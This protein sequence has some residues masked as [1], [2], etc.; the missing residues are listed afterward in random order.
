M[1]ISIKKSNQPILKEEIRK[2]ESVIGN[3]LPLDFRGFLLKYNGGIPETN[4][5]DIP[6]GK[7]SSGVNKFLSIKEILR[8]KKNL[9]SRL[10]E[11][12]LPIASAEGGNYVCLVLGDNSGIYYWDHELEGEE[13]NLPSWKNMFFLSQS[14]VKFEESLKKFDPSRVKLKPGQVKSAWIDP[15][16]LD[17]LKLD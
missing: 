7:N 5:F 2:L 16:F 14:F 12:A 6:E 8:E 11:Q 13:P 9:G 3:K 17:S 15:D 4:E 1:L 10:V